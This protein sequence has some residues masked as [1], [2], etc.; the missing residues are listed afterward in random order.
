MTDPNMTDFYGRLARLQKAHAKGY[1]FEAPGALG[2]SF[3]HRPTPRRRSVVLPILFLVVCGF[4]LKGVLHYAVGA[5]S[6]QDRVATLV[7]GTGL[8]PVGGWLMQADPV[9]LFILS[10]ITKVLTAAE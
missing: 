6:Y 7:A 1:A 8:A 5:Q 4:L 3:Y 9:T 2:R 10:Q